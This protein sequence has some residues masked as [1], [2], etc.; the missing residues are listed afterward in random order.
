MKIEKL[1][2]PAKLY[3]IFY[4]NLKV[5]KTIGLTFS[6]FDKFS[7]FMSAPYPGIANEKDCSSVLL[8]SFC[9]F[10]IFLRYILVFYIMCISYA[11][12]V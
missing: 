8:I 1:S 9:T 2:I 5:L 10:I 4:E 7:I 6:R 12:T 3:P 11:K